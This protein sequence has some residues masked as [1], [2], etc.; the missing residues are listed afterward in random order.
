VPTRADSVEMV[1]TTL[2]VFATTKLVSDAAPGA[3]SATAR[4]LVPSF[5]DSVYV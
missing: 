2:G 3:L 1:V 4:S 5:S